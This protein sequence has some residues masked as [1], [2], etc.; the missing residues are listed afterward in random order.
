MTAFLLRR[1]NDGL[2]VGS[3]AEALVGTLPGP[4]FALR[5]QPFL[6]IAS[7]VADVFAQLDARWPLAAGTPGMQRLTGDVEHRGQ[8]C[9][10]H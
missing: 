5:V 8:N 4:N 9:Q 6:D 3:I 2:W 10:G 7:P 1:G